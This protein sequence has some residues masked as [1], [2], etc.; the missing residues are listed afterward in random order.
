MQIEVIPAIELL[1]NCIL[2]IL[3]ISV[4]ITDFKKNCIYNLQTY[5]TAILGFLLNSI[6]YGW[7]G[8]LFS[9]NGFILG[10][11]LLIVFYLLG[12]FGAGDV[13]LLAAIGALKGAYF[14]LWTMTYSAIIGGIMAFAVII[15]KGTFWKTIKGT[16]FFVL[17]PLRSK[18]DLI[19]NEQVQLPYGLA[20]SIGCGWTLFLFYKVW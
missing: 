10:L 19:Q 14:V 13:K 16:F 20:I 18:K 17:H 6:F 11:L 12:G 7:H 5:T 3:I 2:L 8:L 1:K 4:A 15:W 9:F